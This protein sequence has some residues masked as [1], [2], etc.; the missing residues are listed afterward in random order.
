MMLT[1]IK[2][3]FPIDGARATYAEVKRVF[4]LLDR[5]DRVASS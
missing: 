1:A 5:E 3:F 4:G 2:D